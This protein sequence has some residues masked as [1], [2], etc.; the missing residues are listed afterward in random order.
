MRRF[1]SLVFVFLFP[2]TAFG[3]NS[4]LLKDAQDLFAAGDYST[5][6]AKFQEAVDKLS[7]RER[8]I[9]QLQLAVAKNC[10]EALNKAKSAELAKN[11]EI[12]IAE[13]QIVL[14]NNPND[15]KVKILQ[16]AAKKANSRTIASLSVDKTN[17]YFQSSGGTQTITVDS[18]VEW[19]FSNES[20]SWCTL[21]RNGNQLSIRCGLN[22]NSSSRLTSFSIKSLDGEREKRITISQEGE[23]KS[24]TKT[25]NDSKKTQKNTFLTVKTEDINVDA[26]SGSIQVNVTT[27]AESYEVYL[28]PAWCQVERMNKDSFILSYEKNNS[29]AGRSDWFYVKAGDKKSMVRIKQSG[30]VSASTP[31]KK[32]ASTNTSTARKTHFFVDAAYGF[33]TFT[34]T[35]S[36][37][38]QTLWTKEKVAEGSL[39]VGGFAGKESH[40]FLGVGFAFQSYLERPAKFGELFFDFRFVSS[41]ERKTHLFLDLRPGV[42]GPIEDPEISGI[43][44]FHLGAIGGFEFELSKRSTFNIGIR[45]GQT[46]F[47]NG[48][49]N[50]CGIIAPAV[51]IS[52]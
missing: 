8:T 28:L 48:N 44:G 24:I 35:N 32:R 52:F 51:G 21:S 38:D 2:L 26:N 47:T 11:Y 12:A 16:E 41:P 45:A 20:E 13:Y 31:Q 15:T 27:N 40:V 42:V 39:S 5:A 23:N 43:T 30:R 14:D 1:L 46:I 19:I 33:G 29:T 18:N 36:R 4:S 34:V 49:S 10:V 50:R 22:S 37:S 3:Q 7:G 9:A 25:T 6:V 17:L